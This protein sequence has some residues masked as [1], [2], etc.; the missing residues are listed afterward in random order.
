[1]ASSE[2]SKIEELNELDSIAKGTAESYDKNQ[3]ITKCLYEGLPLNTY[4]C[5]ENIYRSTRSQMECN[6][7]PTSVLFNKHA[8]YIVCSEI[9]ITSKKYMRFCTDITSVYVKD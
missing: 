7:H 8:A 6:I 2:E 9:I 3:L 5:H 1:M 4:Q